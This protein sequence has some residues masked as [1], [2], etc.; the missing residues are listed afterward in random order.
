MRVNPTR[1]TITMEYPDHTV[2][3]EVPNPGPPMELTSSA[4]RDVFRMGRYPLP[5]EAEDY[6]IV[7]RVR[8]RPSGPSGSVA[9]CQITHHKEPDPEEPQ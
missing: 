4:V 3:L 1:V 6:D 2:E 5:S 7:L 9:F 8:A